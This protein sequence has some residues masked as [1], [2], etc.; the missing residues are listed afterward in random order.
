MNRVYRQH[1][2][3]FVFKTLV[4]NPNLAPLTLNVIIKCTDLVSVFFQE[5]EGIIIAK[6]LK[7]DQYCLTI[8]KINNKNIT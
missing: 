3:L 8:P 4:H 2:F 7:L 5:S 6:V 1:I